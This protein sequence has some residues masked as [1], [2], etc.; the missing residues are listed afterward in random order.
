MRRVLLGIFFCSGLTSLIYESIW[1]QYLRLFLGHAAYA[2]TLVLAIFMG[3]MALGAWIVAARSERIKRLLAAYMVI[4]AI[5][6]LCALVFHRV[7]TGATEW[8]FDSVIPALPSGVSVQLFKWTLAALLILPQSILLGMTFPLVSNGIIR[9]WP[10][11]PGEIL[12]VL[13]FANSLGAA[14][15]VL[16]A[17]FVLIDAVGLPGTLFTAG[18]LNLALAAIGWLLVRGPGEGPTRAVAPAMSTSASS[19]TPAGWFV[20]A[21]FLTG[22]ASF[23][24]EIGW[25]RMLSLVLGSSSHSFELMLSAFIF[26]LACGGLWMRKR[27]DRIGDVVRY[28]GLTMLAMG[29][30]AMLTLPAYNWT[31]GFMELAL[32]TLSRTENAYTA[33]NFASHAIAVIIMLP[34]TF[35]AGMT[36]PL[37]TAAALRKSG[38][39]A[40]GMVYASNTLGAIV[41]VLLAVHLV[42]PGA[43]V[44]GVIVGGAAIHLAI[45]LGALLILTKIPPPQRLAVG[46][47]AAVALLWTTFGAQLDPLKMASAVYRSGKASL[48]QN[49]RVMSLRHG[50]TATISVVELNGNR[51]I[52]TNGKPDAAIQMGDGPPHAD[53][54]TMIAAAAIPLSLHANPARVANIGFGSGLTS[55]TLLADRRVKHLDSIEIEPF[56]V[57]GA[58]EAFLPRI[59]TVFEDPRS[60]IIYEDAKTFFATTR[61]PYDIIV[62]EPSNPWVSG[63]ATLFSEEFYHRIRDY[64][65]P[66]GY[67]VQWLQVYE[68]DMTVMASV[69]KALSRQFPTYAVYIT[70]DSDVLI[71]ATMAPSISKENGALFDSPQLRTAL[72]RVGIASLGD[73]RER[74]IGDK[75]ALDALF[76]AYNS[77]P[78]SDYYPFVDLNAARLRFMGKS[79]VQ[80]PALLSLP[81]PVMEILAA[82]SDTQEPPAPSGQGRLERD[83]AIRTARMLRDAYASGRHDTLPPAMARDALLIKLSAERCSEEGT[84]GVWRR[85][86]RSLSA[87]TTPFLQPS[88]IA[89]LSAALQTTPCYRT[90]EGSHRTWTDLLIAMG[91][92]DPESIS[93]LGHA[94]L[95]DGAETLT[96][97]EITFV[98]TAV[99]AADL[100]RGAPAQA[101]TLLASNWQ[102][103][104]HTSRYELALI[105]LL[106]LSTRGGEQPSA[107][108]S[109][110]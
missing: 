108:F 9:R 81:I 1:S 37:L 15:G 4:E 85:T 88:E 18:I 19:G 58:R 57:R 106:A 109:A 72:A 40:I 51:Y 27:I 45:G 69:I 55:A 105:G 28:L 87:M 17:G 65:A 75:S 31:F 59:H 48:P 76:H 74:K 38:E 93:Q 49:T 67:F 102:R 56:M 82:S 10:E 22:V 35:C 96:A 7:F 16:I 3:G 61:A 32:R 50:K 33:F 63:V 98:V 29:V 36:L 44:K 43:G 34:A 94:L 25:I 92:R 95:K 79:A 110:R 42:M 53:E 11:R 8:T 66:N 90:A 107:T 73:I 68:T 39:R 24:Y 52:A 78:N 46:T 103:L 91:A 99:A 100:A 64:L 60:K 30:L 47:V 14:V 86:V 26:G 54:T 80:L 2:Q 71:I 77:P 5:V 62:S 21:A 104:D 101:R 41:G 84:R 70:D 23:F 89:P 20:A 97:E 6:G 12:S 83:E 13:Y